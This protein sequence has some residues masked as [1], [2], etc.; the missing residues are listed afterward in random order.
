MLTV[1]KSTGEEILLMENIGDKGSWINLVAPSD[2]ELLQVSNKLQVSIDLLRYPLDEEEISRIEYDDNEV[3]III[4]VPV[5]KDGTYDTIPLG[6]ILLEDTFIT[7]CL[8]KHELLEEF[9][10]SKPRSFYTYKKTRFLLQILFKT[11]TMYLKYLRQIDKVSGDIEQQLHMSTRNEELIKLLN[12]QKGLV[13]FTTS[14]KSNQIV[15]DKLLRSRLGKD[16]RFQNPN[17]GIVKMYEEDEDL[18]EDVITE[19]KQA[20]EMG[21]IYTS[22]LSNT[23]AAFASVIS[24]NLNIVMKYLT[25]VTI[26]LS[27]PVI[28]A[29]LY[30]MNVHLPFERSPFAFIGILAVSTL[31][32]SMIAIFFIKRKMF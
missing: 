5:I 2:D 27:I 21:D 29:S 6:I 1:L 8:E 26:V 11:A 24:N 22:I 12:L 17:P 3:L 23:M 9:A 7:V 30:G 4:K 16:S 18:L 13:Y 32:S 10:F 19:N 28:V 20:I 15:L 25:S 14:L 31:L